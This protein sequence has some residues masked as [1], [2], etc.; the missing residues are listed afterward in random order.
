MNQKLNF[1]LER[2][3]EKKMKKCFTLQNQSIENAGVALVKG[4]SERI[5]F[6]QKIN[7]Q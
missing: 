2:V 6:L 1:V 7:K 5:E 4:G 3:K